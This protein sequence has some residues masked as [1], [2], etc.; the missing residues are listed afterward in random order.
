METT[1]YQ[2]LPI[3]HL[4]DVWPMYCQAF[5]RVNRLAVQ[6]H[7][8][9]YEEFTGTM[10][11][12][13]IDKYVVTDPDGVVVALSVITNNLRA[14]PLISPEFFAHHYPE[15][16]EQDRIWYV[17]FV[18]TRRTP[19]R[20]PVST[21]ADLIAAMAVPV[22]KAQG[23]SVMDYCGYNVDGR[24]LPLA[25]ASIL[26]DQNTAAVMESLDRQEF[27]AYYPAGKPS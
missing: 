20:P 3:S 16:Y 10:L 17:G 13:A 7:A 4:N 23:M 5:E 21:F 22:V 6:R 15:L 1:T 26:T 25:A 18:C 27:V 14:W 12:E 9:T 24:H 19:P 8:M 2:S 11:D